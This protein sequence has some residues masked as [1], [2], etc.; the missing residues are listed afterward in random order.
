M[1]RDNF[2][3]LFK[4]DPETQ[5]EW[6]VI[7]SHID[8]MKNDLAAKMN[9]NPTAKAQYE[10]IRS[11]EKEYTEVFQ[12]PVKLADEIANAK[13]MI[14]ELKKLKLEKLSEELTV[15]TAKGYI[16]LKEADT[17][18]KKY[19][20]PAEEIKAK[21]LDRGKPIRERATKAA[22]EPPRLD[23]SAIDG[24]VKELADLN[25]LMRQQN[26]KELAN[27]YEFLG[28]DRT[29]TTGALRT[30]AD[31][32]YSEIRL[33]AT[34]TAK[35]TLEQTLIG[36]CQSFFKDDK[37]REKYNNSLHWLELQAIR[38]QAIS[39][40]RTESKITVKLAEILVAQGTSNGLARE[41]IL[42]ALQEV[43]AQQRWGIEVPASPPGSDKPT[44]PCGFCDC[45]LTDDLSRCPKCGQSARIVCPTCAEENR[46][47]LRHCAKCRFAIGDM[48]MAASRI[49]QAK[50]CL[51]DDPYMA[52]KYLREALAFHPKHIEATALLK[53]AEGAIAQHEQE[54][55]DQNERVK[56][57][58]VL[59]EQMATEVTEKIRLQEF[60]AARAAWERL[61]R[62]SP[63]HP[64][65]AAKGPIIKAAI[66]NAR[67]HTE[68]GQ[69][70]EGQGKTED[71]RDKYDEALRGCKDCMAAI[72]GKKRCRPTPPTNLVAR[73][74]AAAVELN[75]TKSDAR[76][77]LLYAVIR[78][79]G[80]PPERREDGRRVALT[81]TTSFADHDALPGVVYCY[82]VYTVREDDYSAA[83]AVSPATV[84][85]AEVEALEATPRN[86]GVTLVWQLPPNATGV[87][88][89]RQIG[90]PPRRREG[91]LVVTSAGSSVM[92]QKLQNGVVYGYRVVAVFRGGDGKPL[93]SEGSVISAKPQMPLQPVNQLN[94]TRQSSGQIDVTW[95][96]PPSGEVSIY[97]Y[98]PSAD[99]P[100][101]PRSGQS[102]RQ[103]EL[104]ALGDPFRAIGTTKAIY[105]PA[106]GDELKLLAV[107][108][109]GGSA[110]AGEVA[111]VCFLDEIRDLEV[112]VEGSAMF[113]RWTFPD[114][115]DVAKAVYRPDK[116]PEGAE[117]PVATSC[118]CNQG[119]SKLGE[120]RIEIPVIP[121]A[122]LKVFTARNRDRVWAYS[123]GVE[124]VVPLGQQR[125]ARYTLRRVRRFGL[126]PT[127]IMLL[128]I[129][130]R[131]HAALS[132]LALVAGKGRFPLGPKDGHTL[133]EFE[134]GEV[135]S[136]NPFQ[137]AL[138][139]PDWVEQRHTRIFPVN[140]GDVDSLE[141]FQYS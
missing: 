37:D 46:N 63:S 137:A 96:A 123:A 56:G 109:S 139:A 134:P 102:L 22:A 41:R 11:L 69:R 97:R 13:R 65:I 79:E 116:F 141:L 130:S 55:K 119:N 92:D 26:L 124:R 19:G 62:K 77:V 126:F 60:E 20:L 121:L 100:F 36:R 112:W 25:D 128:T 7:K 27:L 73:A 33:I 57:A 6:A 64:F 14:A 31:D 5:A 15:L 88:V 53:T 93:Y 133:L 91:D 70:L 125:R 9:F 114:G 83:P 99:L 45:R 54:A 95:V 52:R 135:S 75:W 136:A 42:A 8:K 68:R 103:A 49:G 110:V 74:T 18:V 105:T 101:P 44:R 87:E 12:D 118:Y 39:G 43:A 50:K 82:A 104:N 28:L 76:G 23:Q 94:V 122:Y 84:R 35:V 78:K 40:G 129:W 48:G 3:V 67:T 21:I 61:Q 85:P 71:A 132:R 58:E 10:L 138:L 113:L 51:H 115:I 38:D 131:R 66:E 106:A 47:D 89:Y 140:E 29:A 127:G 34:K 4:L 72:E 59:L 111:S 81:S 117:D 16:T 107:T 32:R 17:L 90:D 2:Y 30:A 108:R 80:K 120:F 86:S 98:T 24:Y 1:A